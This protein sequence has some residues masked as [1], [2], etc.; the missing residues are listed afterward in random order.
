MR[1]FLSIAVCVL[2]ALGGILFAQMA[3]SCYRQ[4]QLLK[5]G[6][7]HPAQ[8]PFTSIIGPAVF[9]T[10]SLTMFAGT[11]LARNL[12]MAGVAVG[13]VPLFLI[14]LLRRLGFIQVVNH[15]TSGENSSESDDGP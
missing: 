10:C 3:F 8:K 14:E 15:L 13:L 1:S 11:F 4:Q 9:V 12:P 5:K 2:T 6:Q 7:R